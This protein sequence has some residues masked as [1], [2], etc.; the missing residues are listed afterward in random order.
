MIQLSGAGKRF[1]HKLLFENVDWLITNHDHIGLVGGNGTG[2]STLMKILGG[3]D[4]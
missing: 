2:K 3:M 1:G 4:T